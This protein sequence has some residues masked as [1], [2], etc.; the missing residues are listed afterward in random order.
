[1]IEM[2]VKTVKGEEVPKE[3]YIEPYIIDTE[4]VKE[5]LK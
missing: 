3:K 5:Y 4:N 2:A 1:M